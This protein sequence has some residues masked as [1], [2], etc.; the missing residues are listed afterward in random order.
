MPIH[1]LDR[2]VD[3]R[4]N[5]S[6][7]HVVAMLLELANGP[8]GRAGLI[9]GLGLNEASVKTLTRKLG[10]LGYVEPSTKGQVL[11]KRGFSLVEYWKKK[12]EGPLELNAHELS[13]GKTDCGILVKGAK[14]RVGNGQALRDEAI[15]IGAAGA[16]VAVV[17]K[18]IEV[19]FCNIQIESFEGEAKRVFCLEKG[20]VIIVSS[21]KDYKAARNG[22]MAAA[23]Y[24]LK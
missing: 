16:S 15:K 14:G 7:V 12:C 6:K 3:L 24:L 5:Y 11:A 13:L 2:V 20:D 17:G 23:I 1:D 10:K 18:V 19:P 21:G 22:A 4:A 9:K 8:I